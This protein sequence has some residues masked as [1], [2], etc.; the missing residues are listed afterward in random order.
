MTMKQVVCHALMA[1]GV[2]VAPS[3]LE[4]RTPRR[5]G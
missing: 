4:D 3:G 5:K 1:F 2:P